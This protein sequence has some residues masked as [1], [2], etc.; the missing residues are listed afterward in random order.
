MEKHKATKCIVWKQGGSELE[1]QGHYPYRV[2]RRGDLWAA[3]H[4]SMR[5]SAL[6]TGNTDA[7]AQRWKHAQFTL[8]TW[9]KKVQVT[10]L[11]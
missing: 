2:V 6:D 9:V 3:T 4:V 7:K 11:E 8:G 5:K 10:E 1:G